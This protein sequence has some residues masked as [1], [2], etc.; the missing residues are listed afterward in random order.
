MELWSSHS[1]PTPAASRTP[2]TPRSLFFE[3][4]AHCSRVSTFLEHHSCFGHPVFELVDV[5]DFD[6]EVRSGSARNPRC[7]FRAEHF[8][9]ENSPF[10]VDPLFHLE[11][12]EEAKRGKTDEGGEC[13]ISPAGNTIDCDGIP[14][15][16]RHLALRIRLDVDQFSDTRRHDVLGAIVTREGGGEQNSAADAHTAA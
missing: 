10:A 12:V 2:V 5:C 11:E 6:L 14:E 1:L 7:G 3:A 4:S 8:P 9:V 16:P 15:E 13:H